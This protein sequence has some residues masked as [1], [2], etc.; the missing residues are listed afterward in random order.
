MPAGHQRE[1]R[2]SASRTSGRRAQC[3]Q[4]INGREGTVPAGRQEGGHSASRALTG[5]RAVPLP[6]E[7]DGFFSPSQRKYNRHLRTK[8]NVCI[9]TGT[10]IS[11]TTLSMQQKHKR[12]YK[13]NHKHTQAQNMCKS[14]HT[15]P[16][17]QIYKHKCMSTHTHTH[18]HKVS[19]PTPT[20]RH[21][22]MHTDRA[23]TH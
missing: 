11:D 2:H 7:Q 5:G 3:Q 22:H 9:Y 21:K 4:G 19:I 8:A 6:A 12:L 10:F 16:C 23:E 18:P 13:H 20:D 1:G 15:Q 14:A 17:T